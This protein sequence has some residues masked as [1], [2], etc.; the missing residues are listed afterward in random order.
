MVADALLLSVGSPKFN[1]NYI[2][3]RGVRPQALPR[4]YQ[5]GIYSVSPLVIPPDNACRVRR[6]VIFQELLKKSK[7]AAPLSLNIRKFEYY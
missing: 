5:S 4:C 7:E 2:H 1:T 3:L 6:E